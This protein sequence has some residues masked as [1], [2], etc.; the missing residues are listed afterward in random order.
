MKKE[1]YLIKTLLKKIKFLFNLQNLQVTVL[2]T[3]EQTEPTEISMNKETETDLRYW[4]FWA[5]N[6]VSCAN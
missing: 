5:N 1:P 3:N 6:D 4:K 2:W